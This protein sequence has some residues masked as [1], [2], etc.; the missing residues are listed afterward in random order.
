MCRI[1]EEMYMTPAELREKRRREN[2]EKFWTLGAFI[3]VWAVA[4]VLSLHYCWGWWQ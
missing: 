4:Q 2:R 1:C 3:A